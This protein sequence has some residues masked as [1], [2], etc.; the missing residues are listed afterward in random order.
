MTQQAYKEAIADLRKWHEGDR[1]M[2]HFDDIE[3]HVNAL[4]T[5]MHGVS[6]VEVLPP[7]TSILLT[8]NGDGVLHVDDT[9]D[10]IEALI[11]HRKP[12]VAG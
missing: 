7:P 9:D 8:R 12:R 1:F 2:K 3:A 6:E 5:P 10:V 4:A 11:H